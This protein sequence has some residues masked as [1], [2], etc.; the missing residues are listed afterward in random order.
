MNNIGNHAKR[1]LDILSGTHSDPDNR[2]IIEPF[3]AEIIAL[4]EKF[5]NSGQSG[6]SAP[7]TASAISQAI[8]TL[9]S[10]ECIAPLTGEDWE[11]NNVTEH[12]GG[13]TLLQNNRVSSVFKR[14]DTGV[15]FLDAIVFRGQ[16]GSCFTG[17]GVKMKDGS[18][19]TSR[20]L[21]KNF[22]FKPKTFYVDVIE[23]EWADKT[24][25][26]KQQGGGWWTSIVKDESQLKEV[27]EYY[28]RY[29]M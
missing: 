19:L 3:S 23:T 27:F 5:G 26:K 11:W 14:M 8:K 1:E 16:N 17:S 13:V 29:E 20:Q 24:E 4:C 10:F 28:N 22:P 9:L 7:F 18:T 21:V 25:T 15:Y 2:P 6:G 12:N